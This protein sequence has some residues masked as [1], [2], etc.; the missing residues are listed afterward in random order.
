M[1]KY[2]T[3]FFALVISSCSNGQTTIAENGIETSNNTINK[4]QSELL[5]DNTKSFP[6]NTQLSIALIKNGEIDFIGIERT[7]DTIKL[8]EN[9]KHTFEIGSITK[10]FTATL[11][12][13][14]VN[15]QELKLDDPIQDYLDF[16]INTENVITFKE[17]ANHTSG[18]PRLPSNL[19]LLLVDQD[20]PYKDYDKEKLINYL[21]TE[22]TLNQEPG[23]A[24]EYS[25]LGAGIL[26]FELATISKSSFESLL[27]ENIFTKYQMVNSTSTKAHIKTTLVKGLKPNGITTSNWD[28]DVL[29]GGGAIFS[30]VED[31]SKFALAQFD[32][33]NNELALTQ[34]PTFKINDQM[35]IGLGWHILKRKN[36]G[37]V[38]WHNGGTGGYTSSMALDLENKNGIIILSNVSAFNEK[39]GNID[40][41][42][43]G[44]IKT[45]DKK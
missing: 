5:F 28:F 25:N 6:N 45:L 34:K 23:I 22:V 30:T 11:L 27:Q 38:I 39:M 24:Y 33:T 31:L 3:A 8:I 26:G 16:K 42:C 41:L 36:G 43:F 14:F 2:V 13:N 7:N 12:S 4:E 19:N 15:N 29:A 20:N 40:Q 10:V 18:L 35:S 32:D 17:L 44:L 1:K 21:T 37:E 9:Y